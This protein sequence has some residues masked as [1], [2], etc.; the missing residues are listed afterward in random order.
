MT[1][2]TPAVLI[3]TPHASW[4]ADLAERK[5]VVKQISGLCRVWWWCA[6]FPETNL[7][8]ADFYAAWTRIDPPFL[9]VFIDGGRERK[10]EREDR[11][12]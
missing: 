1:T 11:V 7:W 8:P 4:F 5:P 3:V 6:R 2:D 9:L 12:S 10:R